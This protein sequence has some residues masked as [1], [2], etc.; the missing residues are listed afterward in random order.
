VVIISTS[1]VAATQSVEK[2]E[3]VKY[4]VRTDISG[5][6]DVSVNEIASSQLTVSSIHW[7]SESM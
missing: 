3:L 2:C 1:E 4:E 7:I 5:K 6:N